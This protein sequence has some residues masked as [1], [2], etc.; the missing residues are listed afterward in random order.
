MKSI[1]I[2]IILALIIGAL[3][4]IKVKFLS[5]E[6]GDKKTPQGVGM[7]IIVNGYITKAEKFESRIF[8]TGTVMANEEVTLMPETSGRVIT[9][10]FKEGSHV[11]KGQLL[12]KINDADL[13][14]QYK[15]LQIQL[16]LVNEKKESLKKLLEIHGVSQEEYD[17]MINQG[18]SLLA[19]MDYT[20]AQISKTEIY[21]PFNGVIGLKRISEGGYVTPSTVIASVEQL[22]PIQVDFFVP[23]KYAP[24]VHKNDKLTF[25]IQGLPETFTGTVFAI[26]PKIDPAT[27]SLEMR[28]IC[29]NKSEKLFPGAFAKIELA[30]KEIDNTIFIPTEA[31]IP[32]LKAQK[33]YLFKSGKAIPSKVETG[34]RT[35]AKIEILSGIQPGDTVITSGV[36]QIKPNGDVKLKKII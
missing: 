30:L 3:A 10:N 6:G 27:R 14:A 18:N 1:K 20:K 12:V 16:E 22:D 36:L 5:K 8:S 13:Q 7:P 25:K 19:D 21:A 15:K 32:E 26:E 33:V 9:I 35:D 28:A 29:P 34:T 11:S 4:F 23:E 31:V 17:S 24:Q 2:I